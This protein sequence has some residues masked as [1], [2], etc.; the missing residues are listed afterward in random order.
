MLEIR[1]YHLQKQSLDQALP[2]IL[3]KAL[4]QGHK[5]LIK[6]NKDTI[7]SLSELLWNTPLNSF[8]PHGTSADPNKELQPIYIT[9]QED[10]PN[11]ADLLILLNGERSQKIDT[12]KMCCEIFDGNNPELLK[13]ARVKWKEYKSAELPVT[14]WQQDTHGKWE[15]VK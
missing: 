6:T 1:F 13:D 11:Q 7:K 2:Q 14:Y 8:L 9:D 4:D 15:N 10:N 5:V 12:Y 3:T